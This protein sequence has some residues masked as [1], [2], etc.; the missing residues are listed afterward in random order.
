MHDGA[1]FRAGE[2]PGGES[3]ACLR[4]RIKTYALARALPEEI[5][6]RKPNPNTNVGASVFYAN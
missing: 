6:L 5:L 4:E 2:S 1:L 3:R